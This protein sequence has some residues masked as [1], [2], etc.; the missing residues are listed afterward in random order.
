MLGSA[1]L[2]QKRYADAEPLLLKGYDGMKAR[3]KSIP[4][5][6]AICFTE[7]I[8]RLVRLY[9]AMDKP[10]YVTKWKKEL[11]LLKSPAKP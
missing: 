2:G 3:E 6:S 8:E 11:G 1:L 10:D 7:A 9:E 4:K 5:E